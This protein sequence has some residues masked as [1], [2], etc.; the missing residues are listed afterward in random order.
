[1]EILGIQYS[2]ALHSSAGSLSSRIPTNYQAQTCAQAHNRIARS[3]VRSS[4]HMLQLSALLGAREDC[5]IGPIMEIALR[6]I[7]RFIGF[8]SAYK[9]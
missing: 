7:L 4:T 3:Q 6:F 1:M 9:V 2:D 5:A 8:L